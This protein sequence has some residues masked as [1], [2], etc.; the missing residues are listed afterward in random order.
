MN[1]TNKNY[2]IVLFLAIFLLFIKIESNATIIGENEATC[3]DGKVVCTNDFTPVCSDLL[4]KPS[5]DGGIPV[6]CGEIF[7]IMVC[8]KTKL[9]C[10]LSPNIPPN[11]ILEVE[12]LSGPTIPDIVELPT[13]DSQ[14]A[15]AVGFAYPSSKSSFALGIKKTKKNLKID[16]VN[17]ED[18]TGKTFMDIPF[19]VIDIPRDKNRKIITLTIPKD[20]SPGQSSYILN[21]KGG[22][23]LSGILEIVNFLNFKN[24]SDGKDVGEPEVNDVNVRINS[25]IINLSISGNNFAEEDALIETKSGSFEEN[26]NSS[27]NTTISIISASVGVNLQTLSVLNKGTKINAKFVASNKI[28]KDTRAVL[29]ISTPRGTTSFPIVLRKA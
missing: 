15:N 24:E 5:C 23:T 8:D 7:S 22:N 29:V 19:M 25:N 18:S 21:L 14:F 9:S 16:S 20:I 6:C 2:L 4:Y 12:I 13:V 3:F 26:P 28:K 1:K 11:T 10:N 17:L 27:L